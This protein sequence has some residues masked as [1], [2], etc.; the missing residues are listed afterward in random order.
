MNVEMESLP[1]NMMMQMIPSGFEWIFIVVIVVVIFFGAKKIPD[2]A[3]GFGKATTEFEKARIE[4]KRELREIK[5]AGTSSSTTT[6]NAAA[7]REK[8]ESIAETLGIDYTDKDDDQLRLAIETEINK[9]QT[10]A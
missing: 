5:N 1:L 2:L 4:A 9:S 3:R 6:T 10:K 7:N 8:L